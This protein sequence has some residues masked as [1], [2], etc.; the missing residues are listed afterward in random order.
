MDP[1]SGE[2]SWLPFRGPGDSEARHAAVHL[3]PEAP[4]AVTVEPPADEAGHRA[5][6]ASSSGG[7]G[8]GRI[9]G[10][11]ENSKGKAICLFFGGGVS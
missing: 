2:L 3:H 8:G 5:V 7:E 4:G 9:L 10:S 11:F 6:G 1:R